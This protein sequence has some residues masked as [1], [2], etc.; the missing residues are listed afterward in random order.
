LKKKE[1]KKMKS[2]IFKALL[3]IIFSTFAYDMLPAAEIFTAPAAITQTAKSFD[4]DD[5]WRHGRGWWW[6]HHHR[7]HHRRHW[8]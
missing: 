2:I 6:R 5:G 1:I 7:C 3:V 4:R 8:S